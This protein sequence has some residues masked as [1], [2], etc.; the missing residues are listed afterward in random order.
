MRL[1]GV[2]FLPTDQKEFPDDSSSYDGSCEK[3]K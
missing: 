1:F 2:G 3:E